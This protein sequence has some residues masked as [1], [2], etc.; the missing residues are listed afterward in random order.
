MTNKF[1]PSAL[2]IIIGA[3]VHAGIFFLP[4]GFASNDD[5][6]MLGLLNGSYTGNPEGYA[7]FIHPIL[8]EVIAFLY[9]LGNQLPWYPFFWFLFSFLSYVGVVKAVEIRGSKLVH[10]LFWI[11]LFIIYAF[12]QLFLLQFTVVA[13]VLAF[14]GYFLLFEAVMF[15]SKKFRRERNFAFLLIILSMLVRIDAFFLTTIS[16]GLFFGY[17]YG[18]S[19]WWSFMYK[20]RLLWVA[21]IVSIGTVQIYERHFGY[22]EYAQFNQARAKVIDHP[23]LWY[24]TPELDKIENPDLFYFRNWLFEDNPNIDISF[25]EKTNQ[26]LN[27]GYFDFDYFIHGF[28][29][30][31]DFHKHHNFSLFLT[32]SYMILLLVLDDHKRKNLKYCLFWILFFLIF[33]HFFIVPHRVQSLFG[34]QLLGASWLCNK[35]PDLKGN[36]LSLVVMLISLIFLVHFVRITGSL[37]AKNEVIKQIDAISQLIPEG[38]IGFTDIVGIESL[39]PKS[40]SARNNFIYFG[41]HSRSP[42]Q[43]KALQDHGYEK[44][45]EIK[46]FYYLTLCGNELTIPDY[47]DHL[48]Q[49]TFNREFIASE[50]EFL[51][52]KYT[53]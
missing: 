36:R 18:V 27:D 50:G 48:S 29:R 8:S 2:F 33:N 3:V 47:L 16:F 22:H 4:F 32:L 19:L 24:I 45:Q 40:F 53:R 42:M 20:G 5:L 12:H 30:I 17:K 15:S 7:V 21:A 10:Q 44:L 34:L 31:A 51:L 41:W 52:F 14:S 1:T 49:S 25:L 9:Q 23:V 37:S 26:R 28:H 13:G 46:T 39:D 43:A 35:H 38:N 11:A 6:M